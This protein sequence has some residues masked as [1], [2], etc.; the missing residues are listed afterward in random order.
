MKKVLYLCLSIN[1]LLQA[2][3][4]EE[5]GT[6]KDNATHLQWQDSEIAQPSTWR[7][8]IKKCQELNL[9]GY[10][11][12][13]MPN[14]NEFKSIRDLK[15]SEPAMDEKFISKSSEVYWSSTS[16]A[17]DKTEAWS[18]NFK[19]GEIEPKLKSEKAFVRCVRD[20]Y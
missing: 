4:V 13:R 8:S 19:Y 3:L 7:D 12:W 20:Y 2:K 10:I 18:I 9:A 14:I 1:L 11:D 15:E 5:T 6:I 17:F 16:D